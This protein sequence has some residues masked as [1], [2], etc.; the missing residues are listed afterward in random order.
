MNVL[1]SGGLSLASLDE[2]ILHPGVKGLPITE[3][4]RQGAIGVQGW[5]VLHADTSFPVAVLK[6]RRPAP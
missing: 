2:Q 5:N 1:P 6:T 3:P 4:L